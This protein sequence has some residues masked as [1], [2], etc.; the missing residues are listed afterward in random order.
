MHLVK[1]PIY[2]LAEVQTTVSSTSVCLMHRSANGRDLV[3]RVI[4]PNAFLPS[5][6]W[7]DIVGQDAEAVQDTC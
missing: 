1:M 2:P 3:L 7:Y 6:A 5:H 4:L